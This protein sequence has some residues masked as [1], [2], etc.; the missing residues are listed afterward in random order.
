MVER[1]K[2]YCLVLMLLVQAWLKDCLL[3]FGR[4]IR[5]SYHGMHPYHGT[6]WYDGTGSTGERGERGTT[7]VGITTPPRLFGGRSRAV[8][9]LMLDG[10]VLGS[11]LKVKGKLFAGRLLPGV[12]R[13]VGDAGGQDSGLLRKSP[14]RLARA[15]GQIGWD[16]GLLRA[17][18]PSPL[19]R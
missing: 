18:A 10:V 14:A 6:Q 1:Y 11:V 16:S 9:S 15:H 2:G 3:L 12:S 19:L 13:W 17:W 7:A 4:V 5:H 8:E